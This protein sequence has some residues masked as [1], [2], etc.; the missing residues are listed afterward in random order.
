MHDVVVSVVVNAVSTVT[1]ICITVFQNSLFFIVIKLNRLI[2]KGVNGS[3]L[4]LIDSV[5]GVNG[6]MFNVQCSIFC[7]SSIVR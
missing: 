1:T 7:G 4:E 5:D 3:Y 2:F 6:Q